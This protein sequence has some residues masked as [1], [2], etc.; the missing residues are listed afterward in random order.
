VLP[1]ALVVMPAAAAMARYNA[2]VT[3][4]PLRLPYLVH[5][6]DYAVTPLF[7]WQKPRPA[8]AYRHAEIRRLHLE[9][10][11]GHYLE[12]ATVS[13]ALQHAGYKLRGWFWAYWP[14]LH[15]SVSLPLLLLP[16]SA[17]PWVLRDRWMQL[18][19]GLLAGFLA[20]LLGT[21]FL[22]PH[23]AAP[24]TGLVFVLGVQAMRPFRLWRWGDWR[25]GRWA[26]RAILALYF[27][28]FA[29]DCRGWW[30]FDL[31]GGLHE[32][33]R[34]LESLE[35]QGGRHLVMVRY[36]PDHD[37]HEE[38]VYNGAD[39]DGAPVVWA[40]EMGAAQ[41]RELLDYFHDRHAWLLEADAQPP[42][43]IPYPD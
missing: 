31:R 6:T 40:R 7:L 21:N 2:R 17:L 37:Y 20:I 33:A 30:K 39:I 9:W 38:W 34:I 27:V 35:Q 14:Q 16:L 15:L 8:P 25:V 32:R 42:R 29:V 41:D 19:F 28:S 12:Q 43:L 18:A 11:L 36:A 13:G 23:Y 1:A 22:I 3:G 24:A 10:E 5:E 26:L 4:N